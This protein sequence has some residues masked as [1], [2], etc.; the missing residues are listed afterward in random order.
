M[1]QR[2]EA[3]NCRG[4]LSLWQHYGIKSSNT[5]G[6]RFP[7]ANISQGVE[8][9]AD[10]SVARLVVTYIVSFVLHQGGSN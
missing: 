4:S 3:L 9:E 5:E 2:S 10:L 7:L 8:D 1:A 6:Q